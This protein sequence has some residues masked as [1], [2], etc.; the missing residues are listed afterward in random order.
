M[1]VK[2]I[3]K[4][5]GKDVV[6]ARTEGNIWKV[7]IPV[8]RSGKYVLELTAYDEAGNMAYVTD[9]LFTFDVYSMR[10][11]IEPMPYICEAADPNY[12]A[13]C[14]GSDYIALVV[15]RGGMCGC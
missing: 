9:V 13:E 7:N 6:F 11:V 4:V 10:I 8:Q 12:R 1:V 15:K 5:D 3:G 2:L 14:V